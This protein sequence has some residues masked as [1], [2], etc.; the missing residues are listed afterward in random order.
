LTQSNFLRVER[1]SRT[2]GRKENEDICSWILGFV[3]I[4]W[5]PRLRELRKRE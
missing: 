3:R 2:S 1:D 5:G 4:Q